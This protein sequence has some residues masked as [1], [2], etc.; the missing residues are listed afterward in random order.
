MRGE[1]LGADQRRNEEDQLIDFEQKSYMQA[2][3][4]LPPEEPQFY[5]HDITQENERRAWE[6]S[7]LQDDDGK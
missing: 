4:L 3:G 5:H 6:E 1:V 7:A 2:K